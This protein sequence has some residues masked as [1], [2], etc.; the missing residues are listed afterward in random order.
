[1]QKQTEKPTQAQTAV[2]ASQLQQD[3]ETLAHE[4]RLLS[5]KYAR[6]ETTLQ[7]VSK[8]HSKDK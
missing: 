5:A 6:L 7:E 2:D 8:A 1:M 3:Y 4:Y